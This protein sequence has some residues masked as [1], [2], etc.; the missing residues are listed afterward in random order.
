MRLDPKLDWFVRMADDITLIDE[1]EQI[2]RE[3]AEYDLT[4]DVTI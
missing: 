1:F 4:P 3:Y 2:V